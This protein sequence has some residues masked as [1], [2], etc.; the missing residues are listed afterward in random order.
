MTYW[1]RLFGV[2]S[3]FVAVRGGVKTACERG[4]KRRGVLSVEKARWVCPFSTSRG[5]A[6]KLWEENRVATG[7]ALA[8][9]GL[10]RMGG[11]VTFGLAGV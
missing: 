3:S 6:V 8:G 1:S 11:D 10:R 5:A 4:G 7:E 9:R 2:N